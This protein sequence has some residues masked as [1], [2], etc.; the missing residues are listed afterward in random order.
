MN[1]SICFSA[2]LLIII[3][4]NFSSGSTLPDE[5]WIDFKKTYDR[6]YETLEE[7]QY[8]RDI[9]LK[10]VDLIDHH[11]REKF[12]KGLSTY[13]LSVNQFADMT[14]D[15]FRSSHLGY[16]GDRV[17]TPSNNEYTM[18][19]VE[20]LP[21]EIDWTK[22]GVVTSVKKQNECGS[23]YAFSAVASIEGQHALK[24]GKLI[25]LSAQNIIDC[26]K[27][28]GNHGCHG[29]NMDK[30]FKMVIK[31][32]GIDTEK[33]YPYEAIARECRQSQKNKTIGATIHSYVDIRRGDELALQSAVAKIG[34]ISVAIDGSGH[35]HQYKSGIYDNENCSPVLL[36]HGVTVVG[37]GELNGKQYWKIKNSWGKGWGT[38]GYG[39]MSRNKNN[40][41]GIATQAS[42]PVV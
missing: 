26:S 9:F 14:E 7:E 41:C 5:R 31:N 22:K 3:L 28:E 8:R 1:K 36:T 6:K 32:N 38:N 24:T 16:L 20:S 21:A 30:A 27:P 37:Y 35:F 19:D 42:Y 18:N 11:N 29:G 23:C 25:E 10:N 4:V 13:E 12:S 34:P 2:F 39:L 33:S 17:K 15:E 40:Q